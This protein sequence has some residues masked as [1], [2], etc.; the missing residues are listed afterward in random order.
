MPS[1]ADAVL[2]GTN[3]RILFTSGRD[4]ADNNDNEAKL[5]LRTTVGSFAAGEVGP[6]IASAPGVQHR[7]ATWAPDRE[8]IV[9]ARGTPGSFLTE[10]YDIYILDI[11]VP[12]GIPQPITNTGDGVTSDRP[13][14]SPDGT[15]IVFDNEVGN[16]IGQRDLAMYDVASGNTTSFTNTPAVVE[17]DPAWTPDSS[18]IFYQVGDP[19]GVNSLDLV[20]KPLSG[21][22]QTDVAASVG[23]SEF[24]ASVSPDGEN[25]CFTRGSGFNNST[26]IVTSLANGGGQT[27][28]SDDNLVTGDINCT[29]SPNGFQILYTRGIFSAGRLVM[30]KAD[31]SEAFPNEITDDLLNFDGNSDWA[32]DGSP[33]CDDVS[34]TTEVDQ[35]VEV[36]LSCRDTGPNYELTNVQSTISE[37]PTNGTLNDIALPNPGTDTTATVTY[38]PNAGF[39]GIDSFEFNSFDFRGFGP[40]RA[41]A[42]IEV[43]PKAIPP[44]TTAPKFSVITMKPKKWRRTAKPKNSKTK[45]GTKIG[46]TLSEGATVT[47]RFQRKKGKRFVSA[48]KKTLNARPAGANKFK[49]KGKLNKGRLKVGKYRLNLSATDAAGNASKVVRGPVFRIV[50]R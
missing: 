29:W 36:S 16:N 50:K 17:S 14:W 24:Q 43:T 4:S 5:F 1:A 7:H 18:E 35:P 34:V 41:T 31:N 25:I 9:Y 13:A 19:N 44:D 40:V 11:T 33:L 2:G 49:F 26:D 3:G 6:P 45:V 37:P 42:T 48:G 28:L 22:A 12:G 46:F 27:V 21:G 32:P 30:E 15:K 47:L 23:T 10:N 38:T 20:K 8:R 39:T